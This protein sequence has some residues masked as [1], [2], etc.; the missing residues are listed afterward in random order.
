MQRTGSQLANGIF[1]DGNLPT[2]SSTPGGM[3]TPVG[4]CMTAT[5][6]LRSSIA[7]VQ[8]NTILFVFCCRICNNAEHRFA[9]GLSANSLQVTAQFS[10]LNI[11]M[12]VGTCGGLVACAV[13]KV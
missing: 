9:F 4:V 5:S 11:S 7:T 8:G 12:L 3:T 13:P 10:Q 2:R 1:C 6:C